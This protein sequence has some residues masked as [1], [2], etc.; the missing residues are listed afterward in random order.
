MFKTKVATATLAGLLLIGSGVAG[1]QMMMDYPYGYYQDPFQTENQAQQGPNYNNGF[2]YDYGYM[3]PGMMGGY[4]W[5]KHLNWE[6]RQ[7]LMRGKLDLSDN[8]KQAWNGYVSALENMVPAKSTATVQNNTDTEAILNA[9]IQELKDRI[10]ALENVQKARQNLINTLT[11]EQLK[12]LQDYE[13][14]K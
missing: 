8:Q 9:R 6:D 2:M 4:G 5:H 1:A 7:A 12:V 3:G 13:E 14:G 10:S 11:P